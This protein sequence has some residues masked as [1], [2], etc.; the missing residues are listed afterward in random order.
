MKTM[1]WAAAK[2]LRSQNSRATTFE[3]LLFI[4]YARNMQNM[5][6]VRTYIRKVKFR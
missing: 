1:S 3:N 6:N 4:L 2:N 5:V